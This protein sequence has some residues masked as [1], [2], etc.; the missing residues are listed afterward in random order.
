MWREPASLT[1]D[2][3]LFGMGSAPAPGTVSGASPD[4]PGNPKGSEI[5]AGGSERSGDLR[6]TVVNGSAS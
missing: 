3:S 6:K 1:R 5:V 4:T 2:T